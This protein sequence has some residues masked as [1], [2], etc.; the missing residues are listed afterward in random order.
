MAKSDVQ[1]LFEVLYDAYG[2]QHWWPARSKFEVCVGAILTQNTAWS[3][4]EKAIKRLRKRGLLELGRMHSAGVEQLADAIKPSGFY[5]QKAARLK[6]FCAL[7]TERYSGK[8]ERMF[9]L[10]LDQ[11]RETLLSINGVGKETADS[12]ILYAAN[13]P[14]FVVDAYTRRITERVFSLSFNSYDELQAFYTDALPQSLNVYKEMHALLVAHAKL[15][16]KKMPL[17]DSCPAQK[18]CAA[19][20]LGFS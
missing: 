11:L 7:V 9:A 1:R 4:V 16:C 19:Y 20:K 6:K 10:P 12:I 17:C 18:M 14:I 5:N 13:K 2:P 3:N 15:H 8:L